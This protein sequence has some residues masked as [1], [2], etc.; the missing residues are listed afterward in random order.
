MSQETMSRRDALKLGM[1]GAGAAMLTASQAMAA[2]PMEKDVKFD[3]EYDV[4]VIGTGFA[5]LAAAAKAAERGYKV[6]ILE[7]M[8][9][10]GGNS[11]IN[12]GGMAVPMNK[13][14]KKHGI[15]DSG[16]KFIADCLKAGLGI[17]HV[18][19]LE[20]IVKRSNDALEFALKCGAK[21]QDVKPAWFGGHSVARTLVTENMS[22]SGIIQPMVAFVEKLPGCKI[23]TRTKMDDFV[24]SND[25]TSVLGVTARINY[26]FDKKLISD[27]MENTSG[28]KKV[29]RAKKGVIL[30]SGG[31][32]MDKVYRKMQDPR[33]MEDMDATNHDGAT[34]GAL[35]K[36]FQIGALPIHIDWIQQG[37]WASP[38]ERGFGV[39]PLLTQQG[40]FNLG[41]AVDVRNG[42]RF[43]NEMADRKTRADA[44]Y[45]ILREA[46][47]MY[48]V[49]FGTY[50][51]FGEQI[52][53]QVE[54]GLQSGVMK[55]FDT[56]DA[57]AANYK[58]PADALKATVKKYNEDALAG[59]EDEF[60]KQTLKNLKA[61]PIDM[62]GPFYAIRLMPKP[63]HTMGGLKID[64]KA[65]V[66]SGNTGKPI[67]GLFAAGE[68]TGGTHGASRLGTVAVTDCLTFGLIAGETI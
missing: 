28:E 49:N 27:D 63:H 40:L 32:S 50:N 3:E 61:A 29:F 41:I 42:K 23:M 17:N 54:K 7:K 51:T 55:K 47:K 44:E 2:A 26:R 38:D 21:F 56:L 36:A 10:V 45:V 64:T 13:Y 30:A 9:R 34:A 24:M 11:V 65:R 14:Q 48:P 8:G 31:F 67:L 33:I 57:L 66:I 20:T 68:V 59:K 60:K 5:G 37:P 16:E 22:G 18:E 43:M 6:L 15:E 1:I 25:G 53:P 46:P 35:L 52:Y 62:K 39:A 12:G 58:I 4:I 19:M